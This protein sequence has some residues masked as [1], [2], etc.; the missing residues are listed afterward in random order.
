MIDHYVIIN[1]LICSF[2]NKFQIKNIPLVHNLNV[3]C[4]DDS[5]LVIIIFNI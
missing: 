5:Q 3:K 2:L 1:A 4:S